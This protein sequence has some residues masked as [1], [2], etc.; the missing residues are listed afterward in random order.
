VIKEERQSYSQKESM[1]IHQDYFKQNDDEPKC[2][3]MKKNTLMLMLI[4]LSGILFSQNPE[5]ALLYFQ[6]QEYEKAAK[7]YEGS[8]RT[9]E[10]RYG[11]TDTTEYLALLYLTGESYLY[12]GDFKKAEK[13][14]SIAKEIFEKLEATNSKMYLFFLT[15]LEEIFLFANKPK[16]VEELYLSSLKIIESDHS[17]SV[18]SY[19]DCLY[20]LAEYYRNFLQFQQS[21]SSYNELIS[22]YNEKFDRNTA[23]YCLYNNNLAMS[24]RG[25]G[26]YQ[27]ASVIME[28]VIT[29]SD[30]ILPPNDLNRMTYE[31]NQALLYTD[32]GN[33]AKSSEIYRK[34]LMLSE[35]E[36]GET[37]PVTV[38]LYIGVIHTYRLLG[39]IEKA[40]LYA[41]KI[42]SF[43][44]N[45][46]K[47]QYPE[48]WKIL[49]EKALLYSMTTDFEKAL[50][51]FLEAIEIIEENY[52]IYHPDY[53]ALLNNIAMHYEKTGEYENAIEQLNYAIDII[54]QMFAND[55][56]DL[57]LYMGN[58]AT[59]YYTLDQFE[60]AEEYFLKSIEVS[61]KTLGDDHPQTKTLSFNYAVFL[62]G[63]K[64]NHSKVYS[65][66]TDVIDS[67]LK[68]IREIIAVLD[69][70]GKEEVMYS[71]DHRFSM[72]Q[73]F[74]TNY[75]ADFS[76]AAG[77]LYNFEL[78][79][80][81][82]VIQS[83][84]QMRD[85]ILSEGDSV[86]LKK[87]DDW[88]NV[89][90]ELAWQLSLEPKRRSKEVY[91][92]E[93]QAKKMEEELNVLSSKY[94]EVQSIARKEWPEIQKNLRENEVAVEFSYFSYG[95]DLNHADSIIYTALV[96]RPGD[97]YPQLVYL[98]SNRQLDSLTSFNGTNE[99]DFVN[100]LY[101]TIKIEGI[102]HT[103]KNYLVYD[104]IW[105]PLED[106]FPDEGTV[107]FALAG[108]LQNIAHAAL[109]DGEGNRLF[110][111]YNLVQLTSTALLTQEN[112]F[113]IEPPRS[114]SL[115]GGID[116]GKV[117]DDRIAFS[118]PKEFDI[119]H[120]SESVL[121]EGF[122]SYWQP[123]EYLPGTLTEVENINELASA[124]HITTSVYTGKI[125]G[126]GE[127]K[128][129]GGAQSPDILHIAT[130]GFYVPR[131]YDQTFTDSLTDETMNFSSRFSEFSNPLNR[132][133]LIFSDA[134]Y[135]GIRD[136]I[137][138][139][140]DDGILKGW[141]VTDV[142]LNNTS[143]VVLS[144][145]KTG[146]GEI[147]FNE[148]VFGLQRAFKAAGA[149][150]IMMSLWEV[151][152]KET[153]EFMEYF[154]SQLFD[155]ESII[156]SFHATQH[157]MKDKYPGEP[158]KWAG[159]VLIR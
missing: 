47:S 98:C 55:Y 70:R 92:L 152:D 36:Y 123:W 139:E 71:R 76:A 27:K 125:A 144:A 18:K 121:P 4:M 34:L 48:Y 78:A 106:L 17:K 158:E 59:I 5:K 8:L 159:F 13:Y 153:A 41:N 85:V 102:Y 157:H 81:N 7:E 115:F 20:R 148:G 84:M 83:A 155:G 79:V 68:E 97:V 45:E 108:K 64:A 23:S 9:Y 135:W 137:P 11:S 75:Y 130:H 109:K 117:D 151:P 129:L 133:G 88:L 2:I 43:L 149:E 49:N 91:K 6:Y 142:P 104:L 95:T 120:N 44:E 60:K 67:D 77:Q 35:K 29:I 61:K 15:K 12:T 14:N 145:C 114:I 138:F 51:L 93:E 101:R 107:Y 74:L 147:R 22:L 10:K 150:Y 103:Q 40:L 50:P 94:H 89:R 116:Y 46:D 126:E 16:K 111:K 136:S 37:Y 99:L 58:L 63:D 105:K 19:R 134:N 21:I 26:N 28:E 118:N 128:T 24:Y 56:P 73:S 112:L 127:F 25:M 80:K 143:L 57:G 100:E 82:I 87:Y 96:L 86:L 31:N 65:I 110:E 119:N 54:E 39:D 66:F 131:K 124:N 32:M 141:E 113:I 69:E 140:A 3:M 33:Y 62:S 156:D 42:I 72:Y 1:I 146:L 90:K 38:S 52:G 53:L 30:S 154:Y 122:R 132:S